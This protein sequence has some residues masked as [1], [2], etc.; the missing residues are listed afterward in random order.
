LDADRRSRWGMA[1]GR[2][3]KNPQ[4]EDAAQQP[5]GNEQP[6]FEG[7]RKPSADEASQRPIVPGGWR[8]PD[9]SPLEPAAAEPPARPGSPGF[10]GSP[11]S[12]IMVLPRFRYW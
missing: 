11:E 4:P 3:P 10:A 5:D 7:W 8:K 2:D 6:P 1:E 12:G 9:G